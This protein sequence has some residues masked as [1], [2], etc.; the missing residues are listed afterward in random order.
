VGGYGDWLRQRPCPPTQ[1][2]SAPEPKASPA[3]AP[4]RERP[5]KLSYRDQRELATLPE[6]IEKLEAEIAALHALM[7]EP[8]FYRRQPDA[9]ADTKTR[10]DTITDALGKAYQ[11]WEELETAKGG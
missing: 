8:D 4:P 9:V 10:L 3:S 7:A 6:H 5:R 11:R 1:A 2:K